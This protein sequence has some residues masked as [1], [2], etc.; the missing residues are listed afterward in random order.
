VSEKSSNREDVVSLV[1]FC[2]AQAEPCVSP[3]GRSGKLLLSQSGLVEIQS[4]PSV[5]LCRYGTC[6]KSREDLVALYPRIAALMENLGGAC[7]GKAC[8]S[9]IM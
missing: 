9:E 8:L 1:A 4:E 3:V 6:P 2:W 5:G 7:T